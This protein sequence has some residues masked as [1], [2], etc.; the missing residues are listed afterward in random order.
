MV[1]PPRHAVT[2]GT[3]LAVL[4]VA[5]AMGLTLVLSHV[6]ARYAASRPSAVCVYHVG[7]QDCVLWDEFQAR[8]KAQAEDYASRAGRTSTPPP[9]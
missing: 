3:I 2:L 5:F 6:S 7:D 8:L 1:G 9:R 4:A